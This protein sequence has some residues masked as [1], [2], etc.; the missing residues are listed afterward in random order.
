MEEITK[1]FD[2]FEL[3]ARVFPVC[4]VL[5]PVI[6]VAL[7]KGWLQKDFIEA[8][9][10]VVFILIML[11]FLSKVIRNLGKK[12]ESNMYK[13][14]GA[15]P[16]TI[17]MRYS[18]THIDVISKTRY[19]KRLNELIPEIKL[20]VSLQEETPESDI[21]YESA[22]TYVR[23]YAN[24][25]RS[26]EPRVYQELKDYNYWRNLYGSKKI[27]VFS[28]MILAIAELY[29][30]TGFSLQQ[31]LT[32]GFND[33]IGLII[34]MISLLC[35]CTFVRKS[36]VEGKAFDYAVTLAEVCERI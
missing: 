5:L 20:P 27:S 36:T 13:Q 32:C 35:M 16:T 11:M 1:H 30:I 29:G 14:L 21:H 25:N 15:K 6:L 17:V 9:L 19:H 3:K 26:K 34:L 28:Y 2:D 18:D 4:T 31:F 23:N 22:M 12:Y 10:Y 7:I 8:T 33:Y 24:S